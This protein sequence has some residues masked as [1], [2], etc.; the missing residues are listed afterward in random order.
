MTHAEESVAA[1][2]DE[3][4]PLAL[5][6]HKEL[7]Y[8]WTF[9][10]KRHVYEGCERA[11]LLHVYT[12]R[13]SAGALK[14]YQVFNVVD[15]PHMDLRVA[16]QDT[17]YV[18]PEFRGY[19]AGRFLVWVDQQLTALAVQRIARIAPRGSGYLMSLISM[20]YDDGDVVMNLEAF[21]G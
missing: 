11:G 7:G 17:I 6:H 2:W 5:D 9:N 8:Q 3:L 14:G 13:D 19:S 1:V 15:H 18:S 20:G 16:H 21:N 10:P 12:L 4:V